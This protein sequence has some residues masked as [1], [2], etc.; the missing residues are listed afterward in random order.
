MTRYL[1]VIGAQRCGTTFLYR[2]LDEHPEI[3]MAKP[4]RPEPKFFLDADKCGKGMDWYEATYFAGAGAFPV[5]G[6]KSTSYIES[7]EA[8]SRAA[9]MI[10]DAVALVMLRDPIDRAVSNWRFST[11]SGLEERPLEQALAENM[12]R[13]EPWDPSTTSV[14]PFAYLERGRYVDYLAPWQRSFPRRLH[15][16]FLEEL[17]GHS[18]AVARMYQAIGVESTFR[19]PSLT[20]RVN[21]AESSAPGIRPSLAR[22]LRGYFKESDDSLRNDLGRELP[23]DLATESTDRLG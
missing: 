14:S 4:A 13:P 1:L 17:A 22:R 18:E 15:V 11:A 21:A 2:L 6:E 7:A 19:P 5:H 12:K 10:P 8:A 20:A 9:G 3:A 23:W 16:L